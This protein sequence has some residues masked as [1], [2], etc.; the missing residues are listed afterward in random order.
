MAAKTIYVMLFASV[1][2]IFMYK[3]GGTTRADLQHISGKITDMGIPEVNGKVDELMRMI[4]LEGFEKFFAMSVAEGRS[5]S[6]PETTRLDELRSGDLVD[7][8]FDDSWG[9]GDKA[10]ESVM[11]IDKKNE[12]YFVHGGDG[13]RQIAYFLWVLSAVCIVGVLILKRLGKI[14]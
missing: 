12:P 8:Y 9:I 14:S 10:I 1:M 7:V 4:S 13:F 3:R 2:A 11:F 5:H 6:R